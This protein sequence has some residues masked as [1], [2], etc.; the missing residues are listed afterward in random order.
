MEVVEITKV[1]KRRHKIIFDSQVPIVLYSGEMRRYGIQEGAVLP[2]ETYGAIIKNIIHRRAKER[3]LYLL[4]TRDYTEKGIRDKL[5]CAQYP[6]E[7]IDVVLKFLKEYRYV[8]DESYANRYVRQ[9]H[10]KM[11]RRQIHYRLIGKGIPEEIVKSALAALPIGEE[12]ALE[13]LLHKKKVD[14][15]G[16]EAGERRKLYAYLIRKG[17]R[18]ENISKKICELESTEHLT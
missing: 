13:A 4:E 7:S 17:F 8:D 2:E 10:Q 9:N 11:S 3:A 16:M 6:M 12:E 1:D 5:V 18:Y 14:F 15:S